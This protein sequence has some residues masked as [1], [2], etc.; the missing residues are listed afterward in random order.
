MNAYE[1]DFLASFV[2]F[3][4]D[5]FDNVSDRTDSNDDVGSVFCTVECERS[6][7]TAGDFAHFLH[8]FSYDIRKCI[9]ILVLQFSG[10]EVDIGVLSGTAGNGVFRIQSTFA[11]FFES[12][13][14]DKFLN[15][16]LVGGFYF[17][18]FVRGTETVEEMYERNAA[19]DSSEVCNRSQVHN[20]LYGAG[21]Q[22]SETGLASAHHVGVV[23]EDRKCLSSQC[24]CGNVENAGKQFTSNLVHIGDHQQKTLRSGIGRGES[25][26]LQ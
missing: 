2:L 22:H 15:V 8:I 19:F 3:V 17:L 20:F 10:L 16:I 12:F 1:T 25:T 23:T 5:G 24:T 13:P 14:V 6:I 21:S 18:D 7:V 4:D 9:V 11:I 26:C